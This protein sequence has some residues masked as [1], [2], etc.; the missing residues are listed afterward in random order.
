MTD[1]EGKSSR[2]L[3]RGGR[4][5]VPREVLVLAKNDTGLKSLGERAS[6]EDSKLSSTY[7]M[8]KAVDGCVDVSAWQS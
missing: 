1:M 7:Q 8:M 3:Q 6:T 5:D 4:Q 2:R